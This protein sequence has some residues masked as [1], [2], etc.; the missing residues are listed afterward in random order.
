VKA[1][2]AVW[3]SLESDPIFPLKAGQDYGGRSFP[4]LIVSRAELVD[5]FKSYIQQ[6]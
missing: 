5:V 3:V 1:A 6:N 4:T 2:G